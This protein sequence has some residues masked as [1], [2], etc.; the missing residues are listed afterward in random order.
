MTLSDI[1]FV[2]KVVVASAALGAAIKYAL[3]A[4]L[5]GSAAL[6]DPALGVVV[7]LL[8]APSLLMGGLLWLRRRSTP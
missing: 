8:V 4:W 6:N 7:A 1:S 2:A 3:P 5:G